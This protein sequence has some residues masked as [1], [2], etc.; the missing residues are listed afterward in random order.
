MLTVRKIVP[1]DREL[2]E[3]AARADPY[4]VRAGLKGDHWENG[5]SLIWS[6]DSGAVVALRTGNVARCDIQFL[7]QDFERNARALTE[8]FWRYV[9]V[10]QQKGY[11]EIVFNTESPAVA[12]F[13]MKRFKFRYLGGETYSLRIK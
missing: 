5:N 4:H 7:T 1:D 10:M 11:E 2:L 3:I 13:F 6:D 9:V 12:N 8:G